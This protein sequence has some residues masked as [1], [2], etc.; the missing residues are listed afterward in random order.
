MMM[1][2]KAGIA[3]AALGLA[4]LFTVPAAAADLGTPRGGSLKDNYQPMPEIV[5][6]SAGPCYFRADFGYSLSRDPSI[7]WAQTDPTTGDF[8]SDHVSTLS[9]DNAWFGEGGIGCGSGSRGL[10]GEV[11]LGYHGKREMSGEPDN[12][13]YKPTV[14]S[15]PENDPLHTSV[16]S[17]TMMFNAYKDFGNY[18]G[19]TPYVGAGVGMAY[20]KLDDVYFTGNPSLVNAIHGDN[21]LSFA[22]SVMAGVG[23]QISDRA[24]LD[25]GYRYFDM[26]DASS[27]NGDTGGNWN[28][29][30]N[31]DDIAA[32]EIKIGLRYHF[33]S[34]DCCAYAPMK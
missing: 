33:G 16:T 20:N 21:T 25:I 2:P 14:T 31:V 28:P 9:M 19:F 1:K 32:H 7:T 17:Y 6:G 15:A 5:R 23:Y 26:G 22:W 4:T 11:V 24:I 13:W 8:L 29:R 34:N 18:G 27:Q 3:W 12:A 10:R 30:V